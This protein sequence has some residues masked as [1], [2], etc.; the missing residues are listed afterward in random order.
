M[1]EPLGS[2]KIMQKTKNI[3]MLS[4]VIKLHLRY[5]QTPA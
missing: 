5:L 1:R 4:L 2:K 3:E